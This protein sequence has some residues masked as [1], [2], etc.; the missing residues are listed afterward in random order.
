MTNRNE[1]AYAAAR[2]LERVRSY[3]HDEEW[4]QSMREAIAELEKQVQAAAGEGR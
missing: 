4:Y 2:L 1:L 3:R